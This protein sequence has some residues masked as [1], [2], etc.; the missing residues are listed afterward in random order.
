MR[1]RLL[2]LFTSVSC[3]FGLNAQT[4]LGFDGIND[5]VNCGNDASLDI[6][7]N[8]ITLEA[9][10]YPTS[11]TT[12]V[13]QGNIIN[14]NGAGENGYMIRCGNNGQVNFNIGSN[15]WNE[16]N[17]ATGVVSLNTWTHV[18]GTYDGTTMRIYVDGVLEASAPMTANIGH[19]T[20][21]MFM[22]EDPQWTGRYFPGRI[23]EAK[24]WNV[25]RTDVQI[26]ASM[27]DEVCNADPNLVA[28]Y[29]FNEGIAGGNNATVTTVIDESGNGNN[30]TLVNF[31]KTGANSN[32]LTGVNLNPGMT[33]SVT[34]I[35]ACDT[36]TW[37]TN[38]Q[39]YN[40][41]GLYSH[42]LTA[43]TGCDSVAYLDLTI[44]SPNDLTTNQTSC[45][46]YFWPVN[47]Q[48]YTSTTTDAVL[49]QT[50]QG[51]EYMH[52]LNV[53]IKNS[54]DTTYS[55]SECAPYTWPVNGQ[56]Y[57]TAGMYTETLTAA[58]GCDSTIS[59]DLAI[60]PDVTATIQQNNDGSLTTQ[61]AEFIQ[62]F[63][64]DNN[65]A[66]IPGATGENF[67]PTDNGNYAVSLNG[68]NV[69]GDTSACFTVDY[70]GLDEQLLEKLS[71]YP[72]PTENNVTVNFGGNTIVS[73]KLIGLDGRVI[74]T[75][76]TASKAM[77]EI[78][79]PEAKGTYLL[80]FTSNNGARTS[81]Q[82]VR[83]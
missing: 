19:A 80:E 78:I 5:Y 55:L 8:A 82:V 24:V 42:M 62:W 38:N 3:A 46:S 43:T 71:V 36:Y 29:R 14:K 48:T 17:T 30:G 81:R 26:A 70:I 9:W 4:S 2:L 40:S 18:A 67:T 20:L 10:I 75:Y 22:G 68:L 53:T 21:N 56:T 76:A 31:A 63:D 47:G 60:L 74:E 50:S 13:W 6:T 65:M 79:L 51:C 58:N 83:M 37:T 1:Q 15:G 35:D 49:L 25:A 33:S 16:L 34:D 64:C 11:F 69:C 77:Q 39:T 45:D 52:T 54:F 61:T 23:D 27:S 72:N 7:G 12:Q 59:L 44:Y 41:S 57:S 73:V 32:W 28:Y 66:P